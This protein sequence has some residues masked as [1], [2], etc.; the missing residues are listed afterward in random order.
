MA[1]VWAS[2][3]A[4]QKLRCRSRWRWA[5]VSSPR[6]EQL[7]RVKHQ[8]VA[9]AAPCDA[10]CTLNCSMHSSWGWK[11][12]KCYCA[13]CAVHTSGDGGILLCVCSQSRTL[14]K[15]RLLCK[16]LLIRNVCLSLWCCPLGVCPACLKIA[17]LAGGW[18]QTLFCLLCCTRCLSHGVPLSTQKRDDGDIA[19]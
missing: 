3:S 12:A 16:E 15:V 14:P 7:L 4:P 13:I 8:A 5:L 10:P 1:W 9:E 2:H 6:R 19:W 18:T 11:W 17:V